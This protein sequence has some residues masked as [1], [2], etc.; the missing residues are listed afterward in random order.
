[1]IEIFRG[2]YV[3]TTDIGTVFFRTLIKASSVNIQG[4]EIENIFSMILYKDYLGLV[5]LTPTASVVWWPE[6][7]AT[8]T[9]VPGSIPGA[10][11]FSE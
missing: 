5:W 10:T 7:L 6:F 8:D 2:K 3:H 1:L 11:R 4:S 9:E